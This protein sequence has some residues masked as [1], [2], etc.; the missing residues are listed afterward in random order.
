[1]S[2]GLTLDFDTADRI[3]VLCLKDHLHYLKQEVSNY[4]EN[5]Q[6]MH[7]ADLEEST[8]K[9]IPALETVLKYFGEDQR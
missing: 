5:K 3:T 6:W 8:T 1:M 2:K 7:P 9:L 4:V